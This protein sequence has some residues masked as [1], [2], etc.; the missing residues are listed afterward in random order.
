MNGV[1]VIALI[2][3]FIFISVIFFF[4]ESFQNFLFNVFVCE[5]FFN[6]IISYSKML[7]ILCMVY[8]CKPHLV[9][10]AIRNFDILS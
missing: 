1:Y 9:S 8:F 4:E 7:L 6:S 2:L 10:L 3:S 5:D